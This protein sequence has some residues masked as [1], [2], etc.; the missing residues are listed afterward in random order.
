[1]RVVWNTIHT[2]IGKRIINSTLLDV[3]N[4]TN[5]LDVESLLVEQSRDLTL[6]IPRECR[7]HVAESNSK[8]MTDAE[9]FDRH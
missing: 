5:L 7:G 3:K 6:Q 4:A 2:K 1:M 9:N 8:Q